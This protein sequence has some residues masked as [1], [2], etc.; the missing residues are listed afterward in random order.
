MA[1]HMTD[2]QRKALKDCTGSCVGKSVRF[3]YK[4]KPGRYQVGTV[5]DVVSILGGEYNQMIQRIKLTPEIARDWGA[6]HA[7]R[8]GYYT[9]S[10]KGRTPVWGQYHSLILGADFQKLARK[11]NK[12]GWMGLS[13]RHTR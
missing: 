5:E 13:Q 8:V 6:R 12:K 11:A 10:A 3:K 7:Y 9:L 1:I 2:N 4:G